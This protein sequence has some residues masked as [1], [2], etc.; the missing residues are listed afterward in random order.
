MFFFFF[1]AEDG[2]RDSSVT[3]VQTCALPISTRRIKEA[4]HPR[5]VIGEV[6]CKQRN[7]TVKETGAGPNDCFATLAGRIRYR[8]M[9]A[10]GCRAT[11]RLGRQPRAQV[12]SQV[13]IELPVVLDKFSHLIGRTV[14]IS[15]TFEGTLLANRSVF[16][17]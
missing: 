6:R 9:R 14:Q 1:Q 7:M 16:P 12:D 8:D 4:D 10:K 3:G 11:D 5:G 13:S 15:H 2:I 17:A